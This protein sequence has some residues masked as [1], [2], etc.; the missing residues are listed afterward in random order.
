MLHRYL[1]HNLIIN[2]LQSAYMDGLASA[3]LEKD[4]AKERASVFAEIAVAVLPEKII[5]FD[6]L[7]Q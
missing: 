4:K 3:V 7:C 2:V 5:M 1:E 6:K